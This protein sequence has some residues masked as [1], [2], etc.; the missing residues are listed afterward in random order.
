MSR[1]IAT[2]AIRGANGLV[3]EADALLRKALA[4]K[5]P[6]A[7]VAFPNTA[8]FLPVI[9]GMLA[10]EVTTLGDLEPVVD[11]AKKLLHPLPARRSKPAMP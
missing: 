5:G 4:E 8:Y 7:P 9:Y 6:D 10:H 2:R 11:H 3:A 1:Y